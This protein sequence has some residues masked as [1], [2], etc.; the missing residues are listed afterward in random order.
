MATETATLPPRCCG[1]C[2][3]TDRT[4]R[5]VRCKVMF[6]CS[7]EHQTE[8]FPVHK[9]AC[10]GVNLAE[11]RVDDE[12]QDLRSR[13]ADYFMPENVFETHVGHF[14]GIL[15]TRDYMRAR[16]GVIKALEKI[17]TRDSV[18]KQLYHLKEI[19]RL[20]RSDNMGVRYLAPGRMLR[21]G[22]DQDAYD[23]VK[24]HETTGSRDDYD[25]G[26]MSLGF[27]D[28]KN[29]D[30]FE[31]V[32]YLCGRFPTLYFVISITLLKIKLLLDLRALQNSI[33]AVG[34]K[35]P[36]EI[37]HNIQKNI[38]LSPI[39]T[40]NRTILD[41]RDHA[42]PIKQVTAQ[43]GTL[44]RVAKETNKFFWPALLEPSDHLSAM[45]EA[46]SS[47]SVE[48]MQLALKY[49][50]DAW[51]ETPGAIDIIKEFHPGAGVPPF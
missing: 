33:R 36:A 16:F 14:W 27:L 24:W 41:R 19:M 46:Y 51:I 43:V 20:N 17:K 40:G 6:Y 38:P 22:L 1:V 9:S 34:S 45:P 7:R 2:G 48:E 37:L 42:E 28:V 29:A 10:R 12:E 47:G 25:W 30:A 49:N 3:T 13:P 50:Y 23:F 8:H 18:E 5:C 11:D 31:P 15:D 35:V 4:R 44:Y 39:I 26:D 21:L 32:D